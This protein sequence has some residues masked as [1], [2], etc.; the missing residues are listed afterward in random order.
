VRLTLLVAALPLLTIAAWLLSLAGAPRLVV[1][2][3]IAL[4]LAQVVGAWLLWQ[5]KP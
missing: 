5:A 4:A 1:A 3:L 2:A